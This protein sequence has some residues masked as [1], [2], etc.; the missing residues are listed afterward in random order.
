MKIE[1]NRTSLLALALLAVV[2]A[3]PG[4]GSDPAE[5]APDLSDAGQQQTPAVAVERN[6]FV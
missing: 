3:L 5:S 6:N 1:A 2:T 4:C